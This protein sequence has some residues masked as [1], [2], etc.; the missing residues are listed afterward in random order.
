MENPL[1]ENLNPSNT[2]DNKNEVK[3]SPS[4]SIMN[5][6][7]KQSKDISKKRRYS[8][9]LKAFK[10]SSPEKS[11]ILSIICDN[12]FE[13]VNIKQNNNL[14]MINLFSKINLKNIDDNSN[15]LKIENIK[16]LDIFNDRPNMMNAKT[17]NKDKNNEKKELLDGDDEDEDEDMRKAPI[18]KKSFIFNSILKLK[19]I[20]CPRLLEEQWIY[21]KIL[22][23]YNIIDFTCKKNYIN[24]LIYSNGRNVHHV[25]KTRR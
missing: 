4:I 18:H 14:S 8:L 25:N 17:F 20:K 3:D 22:L 23:D 6:I 2:S 24:F 21:E 13:D 15:N 1:E 7:K 19:S 16:T 11:E 12:I 9:P 5:P 10:I